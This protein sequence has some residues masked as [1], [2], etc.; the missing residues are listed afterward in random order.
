[1]WIASNSCEI[2]QMLRILSTW[3]AYVQLI[4]SKNKRELLMK[5]PNGTELVNLSKI[6]SFSFSVANYEVS[7]KS[8][9]VTYAL[10]GN[11]FDAPDKISSDKKSYLI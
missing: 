8:F 11:F 4:T 6:L 7:L 5:K 3:Y 1:M 2:S 10:S 9:K